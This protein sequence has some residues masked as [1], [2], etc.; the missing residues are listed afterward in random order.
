[1]AQDRPSSAV[2]SGGPRATGGNRRYRVAVADDDENW[3]FLVRR[4]LERSGRFDVV[5]EAADGAQAIDVAARERPDLLLLDL[6]MPVLDGDQAL[7]RILEAAPETEVIVV[8]G[9]D[10]AGNADR[11]LDLGARAYLEKGLDARGFAD[12]VLRLVEGA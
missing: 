5:G 12:E 1:M 6:R 7:P 4:L 8:S 2:P 11:V 10:R 9:L 3:R